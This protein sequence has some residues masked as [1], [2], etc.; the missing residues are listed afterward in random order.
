[1]ATL[2]LGEEVAHALIRNLAG[3]DNIPDRNSIR[4]WASSLWL[5]WV[6][7]CPGQPACPRRLLR[8][9]QPS[10]RENRTTHPR[11]SGLA[12]RE[13][14]MGSREDGG[15]SP[16][17][18]VPGTQKLGPGRSEAIISLRLSAAPSTFGLLSAPSLPFRTAA[19]WGN[20]SPVNPGNSIRSDLGKT[21]GLRSQFVARCS[22]P[23]R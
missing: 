17:A 22:S 19:G 14:V 11:A 9:K 23:V 15:S 18:A 13:A 21:S 8:A 2:Q 5:G 1:M 10:G 16:T 6:R 20:R 4:G 3:N 12:Q 7:S